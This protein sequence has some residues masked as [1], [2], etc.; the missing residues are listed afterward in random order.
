MRLVARQQAP[1]LPRFTSY[2]AQFK[3]NIVIFYKLLIKIDELLLLF[4]HNI[5]LLK[6]IASLKLI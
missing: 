2:N 1:R 3:Q 5:K 4:I 6:K